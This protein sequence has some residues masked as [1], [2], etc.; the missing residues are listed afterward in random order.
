MLVKPL[1]LELIAFRIVLSILWG[2]LLSSLLWG[3][4]QARECLPLLL[5]GRLLRLEEW[6][7]CELRSNL[8]R[9]PL[10]VLG[11]LSGP[12][13]LAVFLLRGEHLSLLGGTRRG[14]SGHVL[15]LLL[16]L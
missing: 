11:F 12:E 14:S 10:F 2:S 5:L 4:W 1:S 7:P 15:G 9:G 13:R 16:H 3:L 6:A 8:S